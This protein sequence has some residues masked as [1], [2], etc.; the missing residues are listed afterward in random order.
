MQC[1][2]TDTVSPVPW[3]GKEEQTE[4]VYVPLMTGTKVSHKFGILASEDNP[5]SC[6]QADGNGN[7]S[8]ALSGREP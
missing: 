4:S 3:W 7:F 6:V 2:A 5:A 1:H 8:L